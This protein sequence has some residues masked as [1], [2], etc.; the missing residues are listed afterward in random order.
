MGLSTL[1]LS[2]G[3]LE[4]LSLKAARG[5]GLSWGLAAEAGRAVRWLAQY[6]FAAG[7]L[8]ASELDRH[9]WECPILQEHMLF[10]Q[11]GV[12]SLLAGPALSDHAALVTDGLLVQTPSTPELLLPHAANISRLL[13][14]GVALRGGGQG[15]HFAKGIPYPIEVDNGA[16][17]ALLLGEGLP[18]APL[19]TRTRIDLAPDVYERLQ[20]YAHATYAPAT[21][22]SRL[23][24]AGAGLT[25]ND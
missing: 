5:A 12:S 9:H 6:G 25:D 17:V 20:D 3:E 2:L 22:A 24:G 13:D 21:Q 18:G 10:A 7:K 1:N 19:A 16:D 11:G 15:F 14:K 8:L 23:A 4:A